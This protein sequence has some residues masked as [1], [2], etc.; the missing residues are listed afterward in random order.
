[1]GL[2]KAATYD[3]GSVFQFKLK[4]RQKF[5]TGGQ[6][7]PKKLDRLD[8]NERKRLPATNFFSGMLGQKSL[9]ERTMEKQEYTPSN[10]SALSE[11]FSTLP[12]KS[13]QMS[14]RKDRG[15]IASSIPARMQHTPGQSHSNVGRT[16]HSQTRA[17]KLVRASIFCN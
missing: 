14:G 9:L 2:T 16:I 10:T 13:F 11:D 5:S 1:M 17:Q 4:S 8:F 3:A 6:H 15:T 12:A 7:N